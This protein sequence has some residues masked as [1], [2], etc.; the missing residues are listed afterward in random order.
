ML[1]RV[2]S[3]VVTLL[4]PLPLPLVGL[5]WPR[6]GPPSTWVGTLTTGGICM[7]VCED[8]LD[9]AGKGVAD[10]GTIIGTVDDG[11]AALEEIR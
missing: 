6:V 7:G 9:V 1:R 3:V 5:P 2:V 10:D 4:L 11:I 8:R